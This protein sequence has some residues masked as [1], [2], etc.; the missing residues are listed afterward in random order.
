MRSIWRLCTLL[1]IYG[2]R[3]KE[4]VGVDIGCSDMIIKVNNQPRRRCVVVINAIGMEINKKV[5]GS[6]GIL[7][8]RQRI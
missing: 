1:R 2:L 7:K 8:T 3:K 5:F 6:T 4:Q